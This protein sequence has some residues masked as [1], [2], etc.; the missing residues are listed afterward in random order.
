MT[1]TA[2]SMCNL[3][4][5]FYYYEPITPETVKRALATRSSFELKMIRR[6]DRVKAED[7]LMEKTVQVFPYDLTEENGCVRF[8]GDV[9][10]PEKKILGIQGGAFD[11]PTRPHHCLSLGETPFLY[12]EPKRMLA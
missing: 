8:E 9:L 1:N 7:N 2:G 3:N 11:D 6:I 12:W 4:G 10:D 5:V